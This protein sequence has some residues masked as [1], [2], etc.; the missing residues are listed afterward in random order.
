M[1][2]HLLQ[3]DEGILET[4]TDCSHPSQ[5]GPLKLFALVERLRILDETDVVSRDGFNQGLCSVDLAEGNAK[6]VRVV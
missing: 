4:P 1:L 3:I 2:S 5:P 6:M